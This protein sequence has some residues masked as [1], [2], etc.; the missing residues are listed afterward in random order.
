MRQSG[1]CMTAIA[2]ALMMLVGCAAPMPHVLANEIHADCSNAWLLHLPGIAGMRRIDH[3]MIRG[4]QAA[5]YTGKT[6]IYDWTE[7]DPGLDALVAY[8]RNHREA[9]KVADQITKQFRADPH[10]EIILTGH[11]GGTGIAVWALEYLPDDVQVQTVFL[12]A[13]ALSPEYD[14]SRALRHVRGKVYVFTS[15]GD[16]LVL[17]TGTRLFGTIDGIKS[18][19]AGLN[20]FVTPKGADKELYAKLVSEPYQRD[21]INFGHIGNH[22]GCMSRAFVANVMAPMLL[23]D[24]A[25]LEPVA[26]ATTQPAAG[27]EHQAQASAGKSEKKM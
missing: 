26:Q 6:K 15:P 25:A 17:G 16:S 24:L 4:F 11:S 2:T 27:E 5:G 14:L 7:N 18:D 1:W 20:G 22:I 9:E 3:E 23:K 13:S 12:L 10:L 21:W 8:K 19:A